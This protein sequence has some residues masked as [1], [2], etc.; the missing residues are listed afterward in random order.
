MINVDEPPRE[1]PRARPLSMLPQGTELRGI[2]QTQKEQ[3]A[4]QDAMMAQMVSIT[5]VLRSMQG[6]EL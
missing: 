6:E 4:K 5:A 1:S 2:W 3:G